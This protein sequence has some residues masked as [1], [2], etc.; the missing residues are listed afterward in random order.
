ME[1]RMQV[2]AA[3]HQWA[4]LKT[5]AHLKGVS[6]DVFQKDLGNVFPS[7]SHTLMH[8]YDADKV[9]LSRFRGVSPASLSRG[10]FASLQD[11]EQRYIPLLDELQEAFRNLDEQDVISYHN[12]KGDAFQNTAYDLIQHVVSHGSYHRGNITSMLRQQGIP[13]PAVDYII[14]IR[15][16]RS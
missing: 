13:G 5:I 1:S 12:L 9:W 15:E 10:S 4:Q 6:E 16:E 8:M 2:L 7:I 14:Y 3:Y 11:A